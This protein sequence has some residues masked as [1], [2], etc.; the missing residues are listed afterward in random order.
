MIYDTD[1]MIWVY[2]SELYWFCNEKKFE[3]LL[4][5]VVMYDQ[6]FN[7]R[8]LSTFVSIISGVDLH[9]SQFLCL[10]RGFCDIEY[11]VFILIQCWED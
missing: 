10:V 1:L 4:H 3:T 8:F 7:F 11:R 9:R 5:F 6:G 2:P